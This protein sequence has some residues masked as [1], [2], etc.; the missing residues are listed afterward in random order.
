M[1][2]NEMILD[3]L[4]KLETTTQTHSDRATGF[5]DE[6]M[7]ILKGSFVDGKWEP[8]IAPMLRTQVERVDRLEKSEEQAETH[9]M[10]WKHGVGFS[11]IGAIIASVGN[12][13]VNLM[14]LHK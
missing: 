12:A 3:K 14:P 5:Q 13:L 4:Q 7:N 6:V 10:T 11:F 2:E 1:T 8:G 9:R